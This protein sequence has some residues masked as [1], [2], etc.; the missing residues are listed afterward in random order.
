MIQ[1]TLLC[2]IDIIIWNK[3]KHILIQGDECFAEMEKDYLKKDN[4]PIGFPIFG[5]SE[6]IL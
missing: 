5:G 2:S 4:R 1:L 6:E 3:W